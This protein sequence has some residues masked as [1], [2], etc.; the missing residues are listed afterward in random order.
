M[1]KTLLLF[2][3]LIALTTSALATTLSYSNGSAGRSN[4]ARVGTTEMQGQLMRLNS[5]KVKMLAGKTISGIQ[6]VIGSRNGSNFNLFVRETPDGPNLAAVENAT[7][8]KANAWTDFAFAA[9]YVV[10][11]TEENLYIGFTYE[12]ATSY[13]PLSY[14]LTQDSKNLSYAYQDG[15]WVDTYGSNF[16]MPNIRLVTSENFDIADLMVKTFTPTGFMRTGGE[17]GGHEVQVLNLGTVTAKSFTAK[18][19]VGDGEETVEPYDNVNLAPNAVFT[20]KLP[21]MVA[22]SEGRQNVSVKVSDI[23]FANDGADADLTDNSCSEEVFVYDQSVTKRLLIEAFTGQHCSNCPG[24]HRAMNTTIEELESYGIEVLEVSHH[25]GYQPDNF[26]TNEDSEYCFFYNSG[27]STYAPAV[28]VNRWKNPKGTYPGP[29][30]NTG[31]TLIWNTAVDALNQEP[32]VTLDMTCDYNEATREAKLKVD[33]NC[34]R[35]PEGTTVFNIMIAQDSIMAYQTSGGTDYIHNNTCRG[36]IANNAWGFNI[37]DKLVEGETYTYTTTYTLPETIRSTAGTKVTL[38]LD[39]PT[40]AKNMK[41]VAYVAAFDYENPNGN[42]VYNCAGTKLTSD[43][44]SSISSV[45]QN[46]EYRMQNTYNL[47][48]QKVGENYRG[49]VIKNGKKVLIP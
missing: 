28:M 12:I 47:A 23:V 31:E 26:T 46:A 35:K 5:D 33:I 1:K 27:G 41:F 14:D 49:I 15:K 17:Y 42:E 9:P 13:S 44:A 11:G 48:G 32:Y 3:L 20:I 40:E 24:G 22:S 18:V 25:A 39:I 36:T 16:G 10:K 21:K 4:V 29:V 45:M 8:P 6:T 7:I 30:F 19:K 37:S 34:H 38:P 43:E 2:S